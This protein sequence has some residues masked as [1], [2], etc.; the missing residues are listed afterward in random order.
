MSSLTHCNNR[1]PF[2]NTSTSP[3]AI[4]FTLL[5]STQQQH[6]AGY[7]GYFLDLRN[8]SQ[9]K[10][11][12]LHEKK[13]TNVCSDTAPWTCCLICFTPF[14]PSSPYTLLSKTF[15]ILIHTDSTWPI[16]YATVIA[17]SAIHG[18]YTIF[19]IQYIQSITKWYLYYII[20]QTRHLITDLIRHDPT[21]TCVLALKKKKMYVN[22][23]IKPSFVNSLQLLQS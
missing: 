4:A 12:F 16:A 5:L 10:N 13:I 1:R 8:T 3:G 18:V 2:Y 11:R 9:L 22:S 14:S 23:V 6:T 7:P 17:L 21:N 15:R 19:I 20:Q